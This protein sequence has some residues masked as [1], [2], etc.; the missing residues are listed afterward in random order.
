MG[1]TIIIY[2]NVGKISHIQSL[3]SSMGLNFMKLKK[4]SKDLSRQTNTLSIFIPGPELDLMNEFVRV[5]LKL[6]GKLK[7]V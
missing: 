4:K 3:W 5:P 6:Q 2:W 7:A 1:R